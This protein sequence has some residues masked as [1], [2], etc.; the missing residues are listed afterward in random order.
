MT[1]IPALKTEAEEFPG[2]IYWHAGKKKKLCN[3]L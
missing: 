3:P 1:V 2:T